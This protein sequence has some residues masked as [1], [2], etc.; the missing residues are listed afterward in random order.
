MRSYRLRLRVGHTSGKIKKT[1]VNFGN[2]LNILFDFPPFEHQTKQNY[3]YQF[4]KLIKHFCRNVPQKSNCC[5]KVKIYRKIKILKKS[6]FHQKSIFLSKIKICI[7]NP[8]FFW[9]KSKFLSEIQL[10]FCQKS[11]FSSEIQFFCQKSK[12]SSEI[13]LFLSKIKIFIRNPTF[14]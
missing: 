9:Q 4:G 1:I 5:R 14:C 12:F 2:N 13:Q 10:S 7:R 3:E 11:K 8:I 6:N